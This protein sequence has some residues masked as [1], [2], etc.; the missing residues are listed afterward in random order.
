MTGMETSWMKRL[1]EEKG[2][3][4]VMLGLVFDRRFK[5]KTGPSWGFL[6]SALGYGI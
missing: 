2:G 1:S 5:D 6:L 3:I 4:E